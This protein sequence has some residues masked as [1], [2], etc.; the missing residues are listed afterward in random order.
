M[1]NGFGSLGN[2]PS[3]YVSY[4]VFQEGQKGGGGKGP[5]SNSGCLTQVISVVAFVFSV[6]ALIAH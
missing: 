6:V 1:S 5:S 2:G 4:K 3:G